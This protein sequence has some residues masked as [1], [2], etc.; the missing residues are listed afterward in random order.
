MSAGFGFSV[1]DLVLGLKLIKQSIDALEDTKGS[2]AGYQALICEIDSLNDGLEAVENLRLEQ[3]F[4]SKS[5]PCIAIGEAVLRCHDCIDLFLSTI[6]KYQ[7]W[8]RTNRISGSVWKAKLKKIQ[9]AIC[10]KDDIGLFRAQLERQSSSISMLLVTLQVQTFEQSAQLED[11]RRATADCQTRTLDLQ[12][13]FGVTS[14]LLLGLNLEQRQLIQSLIETNRQLAQANQRITD[15]LRQIRGAV[16]LQ[17]ELPP[18]VLLQ[19]PVTLL[20]ACGRISAFHL[21]FITCP[22]ALLA[23]LKIRFE[24]YG[25]EERGIQMLDKSQ[26]V[27][28]DRSGKVDLSKPWTK[29]LRPSQKIDMSMVFQSDDPSSICPACKHTVSSDNLESIDPPSGVLPNNTNDNNDGDDLAL[30]TSRG[31]IDQFRRVQLIYTA[32]PRVTRKDFESDYIMAGGEFHRLPNSPETMLLQWESKLDM[33]LGS[34]ST[35]STIL[36]EQLCSSWID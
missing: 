7:P 15:E 9:W 26:F 16:Q 27:L 36:H 23:V 20:D 5:K 2:S 35:V 31:L 6:A 13:N 18:Q 30:A 29:I 17:V 14:S 28:E 10:K 34:R 33:E 21:D 32:P 4:G 11:Q 22:E 1:G 12:K 8:L 25:I 24:Q 19:K 3:R